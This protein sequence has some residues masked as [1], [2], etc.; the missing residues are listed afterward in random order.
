MGTCPARMDV[1]VLHQPH[2]PHMQRVLRHN[3]P[4]GRSG[5]HQQHEY[6]FHIL[7]VF[8]CLISSD[9]E[10]HSVSTLMSFLSPIA[11]SGSCNIFVNGMLW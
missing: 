1:V 10:L 2:I 11:S 3:R 4:Q 8:Y 7:M 6:P 5:Q 9:K